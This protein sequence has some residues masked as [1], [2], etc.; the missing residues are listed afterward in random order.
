MESPRILAKIKQLYWTV[1]KDMATFQ[2]RNQIQ[3]REQEAV[4]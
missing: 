4:F 3:R 1:H 2:V